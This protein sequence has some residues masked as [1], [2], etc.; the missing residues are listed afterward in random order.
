M[1]SENAM[2]VSNAAF[3]DEIANS[4]LG[5]PEPVEQPAEEQGG[6]EPEE[7]DRS[8]DHFFSDEI[9]RAGE[10]FAKAPEQS[11]PTQPQAET[12]PQSIQESIQTLDAVVQEYELNDPAIAKDFATEFCEAFGTDLFTSGANVEGL[13]NV[14]AKTALSTAQIYDSVGGDLSKLPAEIPPESAKAFTH[15]FLRAW[16][17]DPRTVQVNEQLLTGTVLQ[18]VLNF[19]ASYQQLGGKVTSVDQ[20]NSPEMAEH[21]LGNF[22]RA[23]G[24]ET[25][26]DRG[27]ALRFA[28]AAGKYLLGF[29][30]KLNAMPP[31][32]ARPQPQRRASASRSSGQQRSSAR[33]SSR[34]PGRS[35]RFQ[36]NSD[37][38]DDDTMNLYRREHG[39]L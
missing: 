18:G 38:F 23:F 29:M 39:R 36:T 15:D 25:Q 2:D 1:S 13:G 6:F 26:V 22:L 30:G 33:A 4:L 12:A 28:D 8:E 21:F 5:D 14:M 11:E 27:M 35:T 10:S 16:N 34:G 7:F 17:V 24:V 32:T 3:Q 9:D 37:L 19:Y 20:L 31:Q